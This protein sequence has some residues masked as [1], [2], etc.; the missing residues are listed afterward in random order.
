LCRILWL[1]DDSENIETGSAMN[2][3]L[4][5][6]PTNKNFT[7]YLP[8]FYK[9]QSRYGCVMP[10]NKRFYNDYLT[11]VFFI[12]NNITDNKYHV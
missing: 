5:T 8:E 3:T 6:E 12:E 2:V 7:L 11:T 10:H 9:I 4:L 1:Y